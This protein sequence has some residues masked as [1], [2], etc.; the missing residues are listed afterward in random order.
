VQIIPELSFLQPYNNFI[1][2]LPFVL[3]VVALA[4]IRKSVPPK[5]VGVPYEK[6]TK[7]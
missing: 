2:M 5:A 3:V 6:E 1:F 7:G 4:V